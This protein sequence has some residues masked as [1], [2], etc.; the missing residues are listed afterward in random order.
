MASDFLS[1]G[2]LRSGGS[3]V[4]DGVA[5]AA[6]DD[7]DDVEATAGIALGQGLS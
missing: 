5:A 6:A 4:P 7:D 1:T 3:L 2:T